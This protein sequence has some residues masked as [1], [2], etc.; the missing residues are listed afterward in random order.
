MIRPSDWKLLGL[1]VPGA[2]RFGVPTAPSSLPMREST[3]LYPAWAAQPLQSLRLGLGC[4][5]HLGR[6]GQLVG[7]FHHACPDV[8]LTLADVDAPHAAIALQR[9][10]LDAVM[11]FAPE[12]SEGLRSA[13]LWREPLIA[14]L[15]TDHPL[16]TEAEVPAEALRHEP[17]L[18][19]GDAD[20]G[21]GLDRAVTRA[22]G[23]ATWTSLR[24]A[25]ERDT[26][27]DMVALGFGVAVVPGVPTRAVHPGVV[28]RPI[29]TAHPEI[30][31]GLLW[32]PSNRNPALHAF[33]R[34][35]RAFAH[36][37]DPR[38]GH[39]AE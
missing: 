22:L 28:F 2:A 8:E 29:A 32:K 5:L 19:A 27:F 18:V 10:G 25:V 16:A 23:G 36:R 20:S 17:L 31:C 21:G 15:P 11:Q 33:T 30:E 38:L 7:E 4:S 1:S 12:V 37:R 35:A 34:L 39:A 14:A 3:E 6:A 13:A 26:L 24:Y 9:D